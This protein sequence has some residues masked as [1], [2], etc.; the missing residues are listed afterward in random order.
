MRRRLLIPD[1]ITI[2][3]ERWRV[4]RGE[5]VDMGRGLKTLKQLGMVGLCE[6]K[7]KILHVRRDLNALAAESTFVHELLHADMPSAGHNGDFRRREHRFVPSEAAATEARAKGFTP[8]DGPEA[9]RVLA[10]QFLDTITR[11]FDVPRMGM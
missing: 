1:A 11:Y 2:N 6:R 7:S 8:G 9:W 10:D 5:R 3:G 4:A